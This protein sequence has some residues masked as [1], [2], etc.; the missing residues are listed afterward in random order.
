MKAG[1][2]V[3]IGFNGE[4][5]FCHAVQA[6]NKMTLILVNEDGEEVATIQ[7]FWSADKR[8]E[9][10]DIAN[11]NSSDKKQHS[12]PSTVIRTCSASGCGRLYEAKKADLK[13]GW[14]MC[15]SKSCA[16]QYRSEKK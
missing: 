3:L 4:S 1:D 15:C 8:E 5:H 13:R 14:G 7:Q 2:R 12:S 9:N 10:K 16:A 11:S 6:E